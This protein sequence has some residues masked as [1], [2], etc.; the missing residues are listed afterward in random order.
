[1][2]RQITQ[3]LTEKIYETI[4]AVYSLTMLATIITNSIVILTFYKVRCLLTPSSLPVLSLA[5][6]DLVL[7]LTVMPFGI[8]ANANMIWLMGDVGCNWYAY[9]HTVV[10]L[11]SI[12]HHAVIAVEATRK[13]VRGIRHAGAR[14]REMIT[15]IVVVWAVVLVWGTMPLIGWSSYGPEGSGAVCSIKWKSTDSTDV[16]FAIITF[17]LFLFIPVIIIIAC[18]TAIS[19]DLQRMARKA[20]KQWGSRAQMT[21]GRVAA[22]KKSIWTG[23]IMFVAIFLV[24]M[25]YAIISLLS[26]IGTPAK[27]PP[28]A[29]ALT[30]MLAKT[31]TFLNPIICFFWYHKFRNGTKMLCRNSNRMASLQTAWVTSCNEEVL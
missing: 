14:K 5:L 31:S 27:I 7:A 21:I 10:G 16:S 20:K 4:A 26:I 15:T 29:L 11:S 23:V 1:M 6:A 3:V 8:V 25:P 17:V 18:Y 24:W 2:A 12:L 30:A 22:K 19:Y 9:G 28:L 13:I